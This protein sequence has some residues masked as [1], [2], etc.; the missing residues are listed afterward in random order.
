MLTQTKIGVIV[1]FENTSYLFHFQVLYTYFK[2]LKLSNMLLKKSFILKDYILL[3]SLMSAGDIL[4]F[5]LVE[6]VLV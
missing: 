3:Y 5:C 1:Y 6:L 4:M 2:P